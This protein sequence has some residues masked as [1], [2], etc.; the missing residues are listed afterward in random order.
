MASVG[1]TKSIPQEPY[2]AGRGIEFY[3]AKL[4][5]RKIQVNISLSRFI[6]I[7]FKSYAIMIFTEESEFRFLI[8][9]PRNFDL[10]SITL[11]FTL[12]TF[13]SQPSNIHNVNFIWKE[14][15][16]KTMYIYH[17]LCLFRYLALFISKVHIFWEGHKILKNIH[18][19]YVLCS[20]RRK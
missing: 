14:K 5:G 2:F 8:C 11:V 4:S 19:T 3:A 9:T 13:Y 17:I 7:H 18:L 15:V 12:K 16:K 6:R 20:A 10:C 1:K